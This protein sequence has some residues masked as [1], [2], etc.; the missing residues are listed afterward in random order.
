[1]CKQ[2]PVVD[3]PKVRVIKKMLQVSVC[4]EASC[5]DHSKRYTWGGENMCMSWQ[6]EVRTAR[7]TTTLK[8]EVRTGGKKIACESQGRI[9]EAN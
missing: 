6:S 5:I 1:M 8:I 3:R 2:G 9:V 4:G 7:T